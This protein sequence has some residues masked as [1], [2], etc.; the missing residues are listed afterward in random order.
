MISIEYYNS[1]ISGYLNNRTGNKSGSLPSLKSG[2]SSIADHNRYLPVYKINLSKKNQLFTLALKDSAVSLHNSITALSDE[3]HNPFRNK[4]LF[5]SS[6]DE[7]SVSPAETAPSDDSS[8]FSENDSLKINVLET[9]TPQINEGYLLSPSELNITPGTYAFS[10]DIDENSYLF[11]YTIGNDANNGIIMSKLSDFINKANVG[12]HA[13]VVSDKSLV[14]KK[15]VLESEATGSVEGLTFSLKDT[16]FNGEPVSKGL[17]S[18]LGLNNTTSKPTNAHFFI[19]G[20][21]KTTLTNTFTY[22]NVANITLNAPTDG[23][24]DIFS[25]PDLEAVYKDVDSALSAFNAILSR[26]KEASPSNFKCHFL[27]NSLRDITNENEE[28]LNKAGIQIDSE[29]FLSVDETTFPTPENI[30]ALKKLFTKGSS[31]TNALC[32]K[33][34]E[35]NTNPV[36]YLDKVIITY[37]NTGRPPFT[38]PYVTSLYSGMI[39]N[40]YC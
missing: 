37:P 4:L 3:V 12:I 10:L 16:S 26:A 35:I 40:Y 23:D 21:E 1:L 20:E 17:V 36:E 5:S 25:I 2:Y 11:K 39:F 7:V 6:P 18:Y 34:A 13:H 8:A 15:L 9:A 27:E 19:N 31:F 28:L 14:G 22:K 33:T 30:S 24:V 29:G 38:N 32:A